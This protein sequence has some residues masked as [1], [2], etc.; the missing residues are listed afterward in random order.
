[1]NSLDPNYELAKRFVEAMQ[2]DREDE[3]GDCLYGLG[4]RV[5][6]D[7]RQ[8]KSIVAL[9]KNSAAPLKNT[10]CFVSPCRF[11]DTHAFR[12]LMDTLASRKEVKHMVFFGETLSFPQ[13]R[14]LLECFQHQPLETLD[15]R[16]QKFKTRD[17]PKDAESIFYALPAAVKKSFG[18]NGYDMHYRIYEHVFWGIDK[19]LTI[20]PNNDLAID[21]CLSGTHFYRSPVL[22]SG[23]NVVSQL[24][25]TDIAAG[26]D[27]EDCCSND[28]ATSIF[29]SRMKHLEISLGLLLAEPSLPVFC[30]E[31]AKSNVDMLNLNCFDLDDVPNGCV[32]NAFDQFVLSVLDHDQSQIKHLAILLEENRI[33]LTSL[34]SFIR[35]RAT[36]VQLSIQFCGFRYS[37]LTQL[38]DAIA[39]FSS[40]RDLNLQ[41]Y[42]ATRDSDAVAVPHT[43][44]QLAFADAWDRYLE[45]QTRPDHHL[46]LDSLSIDFDG[47]YALVNGVLA[48]HLGK[49]TALRCLQISVTPEE[50]PVLLQAIQQ[51][52]S[53]WK[54]RLLDDENSEASGRLGSDLQRQQFYAN[55]RRAVRDRATA[56]RVA[57]LMPASAGSLYPQGLYTLS[58]SKRH[59]AVFTLLGN[60]GGRGMF[61]AGAY[62]AYNV[63]SE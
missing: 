16:V 59:D 60:L 6:V 45:A 10:V 56:N 37:D 8:I 35:R 19:G 30:R 21:V 50:P 14:V 40:I 52:T 54:I 53:L 5:Q 33:D 58:Q 17:M 27:W 12:K 61:P 3:H 63:H 44:E 1:M 20:Y 62:D 23:P 41:I 36:I 57:N 49:F 7:R 48:K 51:N 2:Y 22:L 4:A 25:L 31:L 55:F 47:D 13:I 38:L 42:G 26:F 24:N 34:I 29:G 18:F 15:F 39:E 11:L 32:Q 43:E 46:K 9:L 28:V